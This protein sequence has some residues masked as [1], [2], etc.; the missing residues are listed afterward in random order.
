[1]KQKTFTIISMLLLAVFAFQFCSKTDTT[2]ITPVVVD[3]YAAIK[4]A[5]G[6]NIDPTNLAIMQTK[7]NLLTW[8][9]QKIIPVATALQTPKQLWAGFYFTIRI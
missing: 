4:V 9:R 6:T 5:F 3:P 1:M 8:F 2:A 7:P